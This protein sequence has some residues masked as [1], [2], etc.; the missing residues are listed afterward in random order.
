MSNNLL[1]EG[2]GE[3]GILGIYKIRKRSAVA[4]GV[5]KS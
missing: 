1:V 5:V 2:V 3:K 4:R